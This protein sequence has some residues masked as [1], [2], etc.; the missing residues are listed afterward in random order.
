MGVCF[1]GNV[2]TLEFFCVCWLWWT[3]SGNA[4]V[5]L[6]SWDDI[7]SN[8]LQEKEVNIYCKG[9]P[10]VDIQYGGLVP[11]NTFQLLLG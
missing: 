2:H 1:L 4:S 7:T 5:C 9:L 3:V 6:F 11:K 10:T 8:T